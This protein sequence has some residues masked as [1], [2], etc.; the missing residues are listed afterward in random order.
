M[1]YRG[2]PLRTAYVTSKFALRGF[3]EA[4]RVEY[5]DSEVH[6]MDVAPGFIDTNIFDTARDGKGEMQEAIIDRKV[7]K[8]MSSKEAAFRIYKAMKKKEILLVLTGKAKMIYWLA[9]LLPLKLVDKIVYN[10]FY[11]EYKTA[12]KVG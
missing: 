9:R 1:G 8:M 3:M 11:K 4:L 5:F 10:G 2:T 6:V 7:K 12:E